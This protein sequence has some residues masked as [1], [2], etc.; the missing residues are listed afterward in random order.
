MRNKELIEAIHKVVKDYGVTY[1]QAKY[2]YDK[3]KDLPKDEA[4]NKYHELILA[5]QERNKAKKNKVMGNTQ[6]IAVCNNR[7]LTAMLDMDKHPFI[8]DKDKSLGYN[9]K[10]GDEDEVFT[11]S[12]KPDLKNPEPFQGITPRQ[13][14]LLSAIYAQLLHL[15]V[16]EDKFHRTPVTLRS[17]YEYLHGKGRKWCNVPTAQRLKLLNE[18]TDLKMFLK[19]IQGQYRIGRKKLAVE[20]GFFLWFD[21]YYDEGNSQPELDKSR[22]EGFKEKM[23]YCYKEQMGILAVAQSQGRFT[24]IP[25]KM[26]EAKT[27]HRYDDLKMY[28][29]WRVRLAEE[30]DR[31]PA[32]RYERLRKLFG[33]SRSKVVG[34]YMRYLERNGFIKHLRLDHDAV[35]WDKVKKTKE[36][37]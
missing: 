25:V 33:D 8:E 3:V 32:I 24:T 10:I 16:G 14:Q 37:A 23:L 30:R 29:A 21:L 2:I 5:A 22:L 1:R 27:E 19:Y 36:Q 35:R 11:F 6:T 28:L 18:L 9:Y 34:T 4:K 20:A 13:M 12:Y 26:L 17:I 7:I 15:Q 31:T